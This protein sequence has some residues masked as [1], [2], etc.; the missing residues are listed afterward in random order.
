MRA[1]SVK[2]P[3]GPA[4]QPDTRLAASSSGADAIRTWLVR[5]TR[6]IAIDPRRRRGGF[7]KSRQLLVED[8][9]SVPS[10]DGVWRDLVSALRRHTVHSGLGQ[11]SQE[12]RQVVTLAYL[13]GH[14]NREI[15]AMLSVSVST[16]SR[17][18]ST[19]LDRLENY[20]RR[21]GTWVSSIALVGLAFVVRHIST[22]S[23]FMTAAHRAAWYN[24]VAVTAT[25]T[26]TAVA[27]G[28]VAISADSPPPRHP[29]A[30]A[31]ARLNPSASPAGESSQLPGLTLVLPDTVSSRTGQPPGANRAQGQAGHSANHTTPSTDPGCDG[32]PTSAPPPV[33]VGSRSN[34]PQDAP[35]THP[36]AGGCG[37]RGSEAP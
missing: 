24:T 2:W 9:E 6:N 22:F 18:L 19:A 3:D 30:P 17:R 34:H 8:G 36:T 27:L 12:E 16:V 28:L 4:E 35:V 13:Q 1:T 25:G 21:T 14:T 5:G 10:T 20:L 15:A 32:N 7:R 37:P 31:T 23:R 29:S 33:P 26:A 11:L